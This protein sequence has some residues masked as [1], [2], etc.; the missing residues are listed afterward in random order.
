VRLRLHHQLALPFAAVAVAAALAA[1]WFGVQEVRRWVDNH[2]QE[3]AANAVRLLRR[4]E[5]ATNPALL[6][7]AA[8]LSGVQVVSFRRDGVVIASSFDG[9]LP[10]Q[11]RNVFDHGFEDLPTTCGV[12]CLIRY[13]DVMGVDGLR[14]AVVV[15]LGESDPLADAAVTSI[16]TAGFVGVL[17]LVGTSQL[18]A[19]LVTARIQRLVDFTRT[20]SPDADRRAEE[21]A[22]EIGRLGVAF[23]TMLDRLETNRKALV[24][25][26]KLAVAGLL[27]ARVAHDV[28][29]P[30]VSIKM[31]TQLMR[32][33][34][35]PGSEQ[36]EV[37]TAMLR[38][39]DRLELVVN[40]LLDTARP[41]SPT[42]E[43]VSL[44]DVVSGAVEP[45]RPQLAHR[46][47]ALT[48]DP[49]AD[50][51]PLRADAARLHRAVVN[52]LTNAAEACRAGGEIRVSTTTSA[53]NQVITVADDGVGIDPAV[54]DRLFDPFVSATPGGT[55]LG[56]VNAKAVVESHGGT[57]H[58]E[59]RVPHGTLVTITLPTHG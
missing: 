29:N 56:L 55:G 35:A 5:Y 30:L 2:R 49:D 57:I 11:L 18:F 58:V 14:I 19:R 53:D 21:G 6:R 34:A 48:F 23:N 47:I 16:W 10:E 26:E 22:D 13:A 28:R 36:A 39:I 1:T 46:R 17:L 20:V 43:H 40:D 33:Q 37:L 8:D 12:S 51:L 3:D 52:V 42:L 41:E 54:R 50:A 32:A 31:Q 59:P 25:T 15:G 38:D 27:A 4:V 45:L 9:E 44:A 24:R 7:V